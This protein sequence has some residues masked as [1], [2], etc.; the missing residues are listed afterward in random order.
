VTY[1]ILAIIP[2]REG[3]K[4]VPKKNFRA[5]A[6]T[7][8]TEIAISQAKESKLLTDIVVSSDSEQVMAIAAK[9]A[10]IEAIKRPSAIS[11]DN[12]PAID[13]VRHSLK[14]KEEQQQHLFDIVVI[15][16]PS[17]PL[18]KV[19]DIDN[20]INILINNP[21]A[22]S[23]VSVVK[24]DHMVHPLKLK[25]L[26]GIELLPYIEDE[27][28]RFAANELPD[29]YV[30]NCAVYATWRKNLETRKD[31]IGQKSIAYIMSPETS[32]DINE[33]LEFEFAEYLYTHKNNSKNKN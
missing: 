21:D 17:S 7:T 20:T 19:E 22:D 13:Y 16:Q 23:A 2:A 26:S 29:V 15:L 1:K 3:S 11:D 5:F 6:N 8:L 12:S 10:G 18:R 4:R 31:I 14:I 27:K 30:R 25:T 32:V 9:H 28:G 24:L 33:M